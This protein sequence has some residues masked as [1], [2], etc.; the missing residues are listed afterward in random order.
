MVSADSVLEYQL[1][2]DLIRFL[3]LSDAAEK[4]VSE[5]RGLAA[6]IRGMRPHPVP[7]SQFA[8]RAHGL[9]DGNESEMIQL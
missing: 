8:E 2:A 3:S 9:P 7:S 5:P 6:G 1:Q 4:I